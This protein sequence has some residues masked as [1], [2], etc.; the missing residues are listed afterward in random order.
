MLIENQSSMRP[1]R[2]TKTRIAVLDEGMSAQLRA[3]LDSA[4]DLELAW[5]GIS[6]A[7]LVAK[8]PPAQVVLASIDLLGDEPVSRMNE[9]VEATGA[10]LG[11]AL[12]AYAKRDL[13]DRL[14]S[15]NRVR[16]LRA[17]LNLPT[18]RCQMMSIIAR[19]LLSSNS[20]SSG[21]APP[22]Y[23]AVQLGKLQQIST[24]I[25]C[26]CPNH[27]ATLLQNLADFEAYSANCE[28]RNAEDAEVH[29]LLY[30]HTARARAL[31]ER[32]MD[33][34]IAHEKIEI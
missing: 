8:A 21:I 13:L 32:A 1:T 34:V 24:A 4:S 9:L 10:E 18:L 5:T 14:S 25:D 20:T 27:L 31:L 26:E 7:E 28:S 3:S 11:I 6:A 33:R 16:T 19:N 30:E 2:T 23:S 22:R 17:P 15:G 12:Y 29:R